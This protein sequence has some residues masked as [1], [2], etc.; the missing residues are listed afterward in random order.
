[1]DVIEVMN[2]GGN[3]LGSAAAIYKE[4]SFLCRNFS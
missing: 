3:S 1:M 2:E 4:C